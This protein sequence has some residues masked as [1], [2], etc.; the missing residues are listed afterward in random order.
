M[1]SCT[2]F[3]VLP[4]SDATVSSSVVGSVGYAFDEY[5]GFLG[6]APSPLG[7]A[8]CSV[9]CRLHD[10]QCRRDTVSS[11]FMKFQQ[12][13]FMIEPTDFRNF[14]VCVESTFS[15]KALHFVTF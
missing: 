4:G 14:R 1:F 5:P 13:L 12:L 6:F 8:L 9:R 3:S 2:H 15:M 7:F 10:R 11:Y